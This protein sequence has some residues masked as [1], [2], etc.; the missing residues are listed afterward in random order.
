MADITKRVPDCD[1]EGERGK[2]G[3]RG[4]DGDPGATGPTGPTGSSAP[5]ELAPLVAA[6]RVNVDDP[7]SIFFQSMVGFVNP[8]VRVGMGVYELTLADPV[9]DEG[10]VVVDATPFT[11]VRIADVFGVV[12]GP[13]TVITL[14]L[15]DLAGV[16]ADGSFAIVVHRAPLFP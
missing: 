8:P 3:P 7:P 12:A 14:R 10:Q 11:S 1:D 15:F 5:A 9:P 4:H 6:A 16:F 13:P 2:R